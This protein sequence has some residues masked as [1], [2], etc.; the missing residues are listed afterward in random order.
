MGSVTNQ[1]ELLFQQ[2]GMKTSVSLTILGVALIACRVLPLCIMSPFLGGDQIDPQVKVGVGVLLSIVIF[3]AIEPRLGSLPITALP[4]IVLIMK[5]VFIGMSLAFIVSFVFEAARIA[6]NLVDVSSG[7]Q[8]AQVMAPMIQQQATLYSTYKM[9]VATVLFLTL[10][11]H[12]VVI[13]TLGDSMLALPI[14][15]M[16]A[17]SHGMFPYWSIIL[18]HFGDMLRVGLIL[19]GPGLIVTFTTDLAMG[20]INRVATQLQVFFVAMAIKPMV[21]AAMTFLVIYMILDRMQ[22]EF[23][24]MLLTLQDAVRLLL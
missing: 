21:A 3:P 8:M 22:L 14:D 23:G 24:R 13:Q 12:H 9:M 17:F 19:S 1:F 2:M 16:P 10:N 15:K 7:A 20:M 4:F 6:G 5:E 18:R 11:G